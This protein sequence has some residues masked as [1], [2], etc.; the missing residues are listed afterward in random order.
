MTCTSPSLRAFASPGLQSARDCG[1]RFGLQGPVPGQATTTSTGWTTV[2]SVVLP[3]RSMT[4]GVDREDAYPAVIQHESARAVAGDF[5]ADD[6]IES[7]NEFR[8]VLP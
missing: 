8:L 2:S 3:L 6:R 7:R 4:P 5:R 1:S